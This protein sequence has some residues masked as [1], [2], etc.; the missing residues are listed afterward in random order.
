[1]CHSVQLHAH[2]T[3]TC[4]FTAIKAKMWSKMNTMELI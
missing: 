2:Y 4:V 3:P 1:M